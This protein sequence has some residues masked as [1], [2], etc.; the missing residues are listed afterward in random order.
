MIRSPA[1]ESDPGLDDAVNGLHRGDLHA[2]AAQLPES[3]PR[4]GES[5]SRIASLANECGCTMGGTFFAA[6]V[7]VS[8]TYFLIA[9]APDLGS[10]LLAIGFVFVASV[11][12]KLVGLSVAR[13]RLLWLRRVLTARLASVEVSRVHLH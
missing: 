8:V 9:G 10:G 6:A 3:D 4:I 13:I 11:V 2:L 5:R 1:N 12:G 7:A